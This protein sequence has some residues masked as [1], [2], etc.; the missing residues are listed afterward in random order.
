MV[1]YAAV[2]TAV[3]QLSTV[4]FGTLLRVD[5]LLI[6]LEID[7][8]VLVCGGLVCA[9][10]LFWGLRKSRT[11]R[12]TRAALVESNVNAVTDLRFKL[13]IWPV[14]HIRNTVQHVGSDVRPRRP[15][16]P[17]KIEAAT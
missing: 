16:P 11:V 17:S 8:G 13:P 10:A 6:L 4:V 12:D 15:L 5:G 14:S 7:A 1:V 2:Y 9:A 3:V